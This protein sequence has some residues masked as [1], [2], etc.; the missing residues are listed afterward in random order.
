MTREFETIIGSGGW[1]IVYLGFINDSLE[2][3]DPEVGKRVS[4][5]LYYPTM[6]EGR[7]QWQIKMKFL[8]QFDHQN[9]VKLIGYCN[10]AEDM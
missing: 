5:K 10:Q 3:A 8:P 9:L 1:G 7:R 6:K 2:A 4:V